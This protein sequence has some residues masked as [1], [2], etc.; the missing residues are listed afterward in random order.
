MKKLDKFVD[1]LIKSIPK[2][3][4]V[5]L[6]LK[7]Q[8]S[9][10][11]L[12]WLKQDDRDMLSVTKK[13]ASEM[14]K[15]FATSYSKGKLVEA[16]DKAM[17]QACIKAGEVFKSIVLK[18]FGTGYKDIPLKALTKEYIK[19]KGNNKIGYDTGSLYRDIKSST[20]KVKI[21]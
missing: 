1:D 3:V 8:E 2:S 20:I 18:R 10:D 19:S 21:H 5:S 6:D 11:K 12:W 7:N 16:P 14:I 4:S 13:N 15:T 9:A 17:E